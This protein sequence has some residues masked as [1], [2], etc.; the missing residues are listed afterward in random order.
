MYF[1]ECKCIEEVKEIYRTM[2]RKL[3]PDVNT[4]PNATQ[5]MQDLNRQYEL[6]F[7]LLKNIHRSIKDATE[8]YTAKEETKEIPSDFIEII[9]AIIAL[10]G[11]TIELIGRWVWVTGETKQYK[12]IFKAHKFA[13]SNP[14]QAWSWHKP[15]DATHNRKRIPL[16]KIRE[17]YGSQEI[18]QQQNNRAAL[19]A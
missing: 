13:W 9:N 17:M 12:D 16:D 8:V 10:Q 4:A 19:T 5:Q 1:S 11:I 6:A 15:E 2:A 3:H 7:N 18:N 14:K